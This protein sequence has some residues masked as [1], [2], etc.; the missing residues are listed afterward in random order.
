[1]SRD[2]RTDLIRIISA[3]TAY[4]AQFVMCLPQRLAQ[5]KLQGDCT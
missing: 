5:R 2:Y 4:S 1:M 3:Y